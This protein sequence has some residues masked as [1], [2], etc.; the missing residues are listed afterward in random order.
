MRSTLPIVLTL[1]T[2]CAD[3]RLDLDEGMLAEAGPAGDVSVPPGEPRDAVLDPD[4][5]VTDGRPSSADGADD[6]D[7]NMPEPPK[8]DGS[9]PPT[10]DAGPPVP[11]TIDCVYDS[12]S[13]GQSLQHLD[14]GPGSP[15]RLVFTVPGVPAPELVEQAE[16]RFDSFDADHP[17]QEGVILVNGQGPF[18]LPARAEWDNLAGT[19]VV[20][21]SGATQ[22]GENRIEFGPG[23]LE[24]SAFGIGEVRLHTRVRLTECPEAPPPPPPPPEAEVREVRYP[25]ARYTNRSTWVVGCEGNGARAYAFTAQAEEHVGTDCEGLYRAGGNRRGDAVFSFEGLVPAEYEVVVGSRHTENRSPEGALFL[26]DGEG[27]RISQRSERDFTEDVWGRA[28]LEEGRAEVVLR[29]EGGSD[30]VIFVRLVP[31]G[32]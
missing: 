5:E 24:R 7:A 26:V 32:G 4:A 1:C 25:Q 29:A 15:A 23:P 8:P 9:Q 13:V 18:D 19:G 17:G 31:V 2:A 20:D 11:G 28:R 3:A 27:R 30:C 21:V 10:S 22:E 12:D 14:V 16:L 6:A